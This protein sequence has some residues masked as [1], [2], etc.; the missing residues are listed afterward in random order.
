M[1]DYIMKFMDGHFGEGTWHME[2]HDGYVDFHLDEYDNVS[3]RT[4]LEL[5]G[6]VGESFRIMTGHKDNLRIRIY[7]KITWEGDEK[8]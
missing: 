1:I 8:C 2:K 7:T 4:V 6:I 5:G 3:S